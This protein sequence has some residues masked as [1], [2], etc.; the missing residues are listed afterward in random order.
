MFYITILFYRNFIDK[1]KLPVIQNSQNDK[2]IITQKNCE[3]TI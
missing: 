3:G 2:K 1:K